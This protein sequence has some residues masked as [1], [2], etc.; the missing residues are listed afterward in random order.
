MAETADPEH[1]NDVAGARG[2]V[3]QRIEGRV[4][5]HSRGAASALESSSGTEATAIDGAIM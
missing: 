5:A 4:P 2:T 1:R 3:A